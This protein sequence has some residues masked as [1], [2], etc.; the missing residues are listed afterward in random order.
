MNAKKEQKISFKIDKI[1]TESFSLN[2]LGISSFTRDSV[3][4]NFSLKLEIN[5]NKNRLIFALGLIVTPK[6]NKDKQIGN[7]DIKVHFLIKDMSNLVEV[8]KEKENIRLPNVLMI[9]FLSIVISTARGIWSEKVRG[10]K[11]EKA[12]IPLLDPKKFL[13]N[14]SQS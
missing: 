3:N 13:D 11:L 12:I 14:P 6:T 2:L 1:E 5:P 7:L 9:T 4:F 8:E 10:T